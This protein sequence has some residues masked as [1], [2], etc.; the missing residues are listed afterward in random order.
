MDVP[1]LIITGLV[2]LIA[3][4]TKFLVGLMHGRDRRFF[5]SGGMPSVHAAVIVGATTAISLVEGVGSSLFALGV[6]VSAIVVH[7]AVRV[8]WPL[9]EQAVRLN[10]LSQKAKL[11]AVPVIRGHRIREVVAGGVYG[12]LLAAALYRLFWQ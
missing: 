4:T 11:P 2:W 9:G 8:R 12:A 1:V 6:V 10:R 7:D 5:D 3:E